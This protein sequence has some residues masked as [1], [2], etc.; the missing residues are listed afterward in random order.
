MHTQSTIK[1][2]EECLEESVGEAWENHVQDA[3]YRAKALEKLGR[4]IYSDQR[5]KA[6]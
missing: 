1:S 6:A 2:L 3:L 5:K 4:V